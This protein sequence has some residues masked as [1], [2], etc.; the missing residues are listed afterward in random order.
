MDTGWLWAF[1][2]PETV[3]RYF[4]VFCIFQDD[5]QMNPTSSDYKSPYRQEILNSN[6]YVQSVDRSFIMN[7]PPWQ[8]HEEW[9][10]VCEGRSAGAIGGNGVRDPWA[11]LM[12]VLLRFCKAE[13]TSRCMSE[14]VVGP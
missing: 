5:F 2:V 12:P 1:Y 7:A 14:N 11:M 4:Y 8:S 13:C 9:H 10:G 6:V 3:E